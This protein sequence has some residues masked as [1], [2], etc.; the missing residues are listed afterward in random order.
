MRVAVAIVLINIM[1]L[2]F[3]GLSLF[4]NPIVP[5]SVRKLF[6]GLDVAALMA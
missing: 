1:R 5:Y 4:Q 2:R 3:A 6:T